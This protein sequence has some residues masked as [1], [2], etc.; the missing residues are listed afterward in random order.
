MERR[1]ATVELLLEEATEASVGGLEDES[2]LARFLIE[3]AG[4]AV[5]WMSPE[6]DFVYANK[7]ACAML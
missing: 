2:N 7:A 6:L 5:Y 4:E 1:D 3:H